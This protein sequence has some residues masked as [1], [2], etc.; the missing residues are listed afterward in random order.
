LPIISMFYGIIIYMYY[1]DNKQHHIAHIHV[2]Y[3]GAEAVIS[4]PNGELLDGQIP[5][6]QL[7]MVQAWIV[8]HEDELLADWQIAV[9]EENLFKIDP[10]K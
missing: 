5:N 2:E 7:K 1:R 10:L 3:Q 4:I 6:K 8:I 9:R